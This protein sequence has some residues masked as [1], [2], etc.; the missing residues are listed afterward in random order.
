MSQ[1]LRYRYRLTVIDIAHFTHDSSNTI[2]RVELLLVWQFPRQDFTHLEPL[3][4][5]DIA[6]RLGIV[7]APF[8]L[9]AS[10]AHHTP[11]L[12]HCQSIRRFAHIFEIIL[13]KLLGN[14]ARLREMVRVDRV[15]MIHMSVRVRVGFSIAS[16]VSVVLGGRVGAGS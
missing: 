14:L 2:V 1:I 3:P 13:V 8:A 10:S 7:V 4:L 16:A 12:G 15:G 5:V 9:P 11:R 6:Q